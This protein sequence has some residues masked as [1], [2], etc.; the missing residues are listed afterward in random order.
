MENTI[1]E[2]AVAYQR[3]Y[4]PEEYLEMEWVNGVRYEYWEGELIEMSGGTKAH[5]LIAGN[6]NAFF[7]SK[8]KARKCLSFQMN[9]LLKIKERAIYFLPDVVVTCDQQDLDL[10]E[11]TVQ[12]PV[13]VAEVLSKSNEMYD[14]TKKWDMY[15]QIRSLRYYLLISQESYRVELFWRQSNTAIYSYQVFSG[16]Q[17]VI[18]F[19]EWGL[20]LPLEVI[21]EDINLEI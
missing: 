17:S 6:M 16:I 20:E 13:L 7:R 2:P 10:E 14:R 9:I 8:L 12:N 18:S 15:R 11:R 5:G 4:T 19:T 21:Y 3:H 1:Q